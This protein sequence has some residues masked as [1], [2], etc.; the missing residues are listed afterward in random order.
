MYE[1]MQGLFHKEINKYILNTLNIDEQLNIKQIDDK[2]IKSIAN[3]IKNLEF[4]VISY[5]ENNQV[6]TGGVSLNDLDINLQS[7]KCPNLYFAGEI[8]DVDGVCG[9]YNLQ[10]AW[11]S[12]KIVGDNL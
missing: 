1:F 3:K 12:G 6:K 5:Y 7:K 10:W 2:L 4:D 9:G 11:T 8:C